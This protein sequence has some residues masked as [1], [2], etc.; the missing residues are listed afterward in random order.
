[1]PDEA[2]PYSILAEGYDVVM[3]HVDYDGWVAYIE[4][5]LYMHGGPPR[6][7][8]ELGCGTGTFAHLFASIHDVPYL[9]TDGSDDMIRA[10]RRKHAE[11]DSPVAF[12]TADFFDLSGLGSADLVLLL[13]DGLNYITQ[14]ARLPDLF[15]QAYDLLDPGG[16]FIF[17]QATPANSIRNRAFFE[18][19]GTC[20]AFDYVRR[21]EFD[22]R[23]GLHTTTF[24]ISSP[25]GV[26]REEHVQ[27]PYG[28]SEI[29]DI[30]SAGPLEIIASYPDFLLKQV[31][32]SA[33]RIHW[34]T[35]RPVETGK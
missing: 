25:K 24:E 4:E 35:R 28:F 11:D 10:A 34:V 29:R 19:E 15:R 7:V 33:E 22:T 6:S 14:K 5:L 30:L 8:I 9:A 1:M 23:T 18:E 13:Y 21:S 31:D 32:S 26:C 3:S 17:D 20:P 27:R 2:R 16:R 12:R